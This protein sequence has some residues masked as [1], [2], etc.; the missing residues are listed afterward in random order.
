MIYARLRPHR[1]RR[2]PRVPVGLPADH[3]LLVAEHRHDQVSSA[4]K[5]GGMDKLKGKK[6]VHLYHDSA[7]GK[8]TD[9]GARRARRR[10]YGFELTHDPGAASGQRAGSA[11]AADPPDQA[12]LRD[13]VGLGRDEPDRAQG[14]GEGRLPARQD[15][16]RLVGGRRGGH[17]FPRATRRR[18][19]SRPAST[20]SGANFPVIQDIKKYV[21]AQGQGQLEDQTRIGSVYYNAR[22]RARHP[23]RR[24]DPQGA[25]EV[26]QGSR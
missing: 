4:Q 11:V 7:Y 16:R 10:S 24:G 15:P 8:E 1:R 13:P 17:R 12:R 18:A 9:P 19:T 5:E 14:R 20:S 22:R 3:E 6:I 25:G 26:R 2:R 21:Y 23:H